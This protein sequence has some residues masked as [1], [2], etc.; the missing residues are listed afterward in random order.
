MRKFVFCSKKFGKVL[1]TKNLLNLETFSCFSYDEYFEL[2]L[3]KL[4]CPISSVLNTTDQM[5]LKR[6]AT[7]HDDKKL[8]DD[9]KKLY[10][11]LFIDFDLCSPLRKCSIKFTY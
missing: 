8:V 4:S 7:K 11:F 5:F 1:L 2:T 9:T 3:S 10:S 6:H